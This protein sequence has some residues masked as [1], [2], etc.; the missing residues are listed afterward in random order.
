[1]AQPPITG[2]QIDE[3][4][5]Q[6]T[7]DSGI[8]FPGS[9]TLGDLFFLTTDIV[10]GSPTYATHF[11]GAHVYDGSIWITK[12]QASTEANYGWREMIYPIM[13]VDPGAPATSPDWEI[14]RDG[15]SAY[16]FDDT[17][18]EQAWWSCHIPHDWAVGTSIFPHV[19]WSH[20]QASPSGTVRWGIEYTMAKGYGEGNFPASTTVYIEQVAGGGSPTTGS[21]Y[22][23]FITEFS[24]AQSIDM[25]SMDIDGIIIFRLFRD[26]SHANDTFVGDASVLFT[27]AHYQSD[28]RVTPQ[29][30]SPFTKLT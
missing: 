22:Q 9:P 18:I 23:H 30:N 24:E 17:T 8:S 1:M 3:S 19:H 26:A 2:D 10:V 14:F 25:S 5:L 16:A 21:Q 4:T 29:R 27:D 15:L 6:Y 13:F 7:L 11:K 28:E 12:P 20:N